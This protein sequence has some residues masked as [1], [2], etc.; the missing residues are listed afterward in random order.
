MMMMWP[1]MK[2]SLTPLYLA[3]KKNKRNG[4]LWSLSCS[5]GAAAFQL[6]KRM[7]QREKRV[8][9]KKERDY[10]QTGCWPLLSLSSVYDV[11][12]HPVSLDVEENAPWREERNTFW[13][14]SERLKR[15]TYPE[16]I[17][18]VTG[19]HP[20]LKCGVYPP[21]YI[22]IYIY[23]SMWWEKETQNGSGGAFSSFHALSPQALQYAVPEAAVSGGPAPSSG[24][25]QRWK[26]S[27]GLP[28]GGTG[29]VGLDEVCLAWLIL[30]S[31]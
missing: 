8:R 15:S 16:A 20:C 13:F 19:K 21:G 22:Y 24:R 26:E 14:K 4:I 25:I 18:L 28:S 7:Y 1:T 6:L 27:S 11:W 12:F 3:G 9:Q 23:G 10:I 30:P 2:M 29:W 31:S 17:P 5:F